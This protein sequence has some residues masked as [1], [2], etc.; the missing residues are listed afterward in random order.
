[1]PECDWEKYSEEQ[2]MNLTS[3]LFVLIVVALTVLAS[4]SNVVASSPG[5]ARI[6][7]T[8]TEL[9]NILNALEMYK[10]DHGD[11]PT[12]SQGLSALVEKPVRESESVNWS[13][14]LIKL[15]QDPW[16]RNYL[17]RNPGVFDDVEVFSLGR[18]GK[19]GGCGESADVYSSTYEGIDSKK[20]KS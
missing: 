7:K 1:V 4:A 13:A 17:Y 19:P 20:C 3:Y 16:G 8:K 9:G 6:A 10:L 14:Y 5:D 15:P 12:A 2:T 11:F 18:D